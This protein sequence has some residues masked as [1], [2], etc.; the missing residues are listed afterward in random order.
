VVDQVVESGASASP[1]FWRQMMGQQEI[2]ALIVWTDNP[3]L[4]GLVAL[5][6]ERQL[7]PIFV[8]DD[9]YSGGPPSFDARLKEHLRFISTLNPSEH[10][11]AAPAM[12]AWSDWMNSHHLEKSEALLQANT[13]CVMSL[14]DEA[15]RAN[16]GDFTPEHLIE[17]IEYWVGCVVG[18]VRV[19]GV[20][21]V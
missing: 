3:D 11:A 1:E 9:P 19:C 18:V 10:A 17:R 5:A 16:A 12:A 6:S 21:P 13:W 2:C 14:V 15:V 7:P 4:A 20:G 8:A